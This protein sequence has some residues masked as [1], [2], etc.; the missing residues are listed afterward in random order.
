MAMC[1][2][3]LRSWDDSPSIVNGKIIYQRHCPSNSLGQQLDEWT[4]LYK[5][6]KMWF[7]TELCL[8]ASLNYISWV[9]MVT[10]TALWPGCCLVIP[11]FIPC[12]LG[13]PSHHLSFDQKG[14]H[15][16]CT[17][18]AQ[19]LPYLLCQGWFIHTAPKWT[20]PVYRFH[21]NLA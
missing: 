13:G 14:S 18:W 17:S 10:W 3:L 7:H 11:I 8:Q 21:S 2:E 16:W 9:Y 15:N 19:L 12:P 4:F 20:A 5:L 6:H 1:G